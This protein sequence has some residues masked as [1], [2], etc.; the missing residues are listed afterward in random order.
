MVQNR[1]TNILE[2]YLQEKIKT[3]VSIGSIRLDLPESLVLEGLY[4][5]NP[6]QD[7]FLSLGELSINFKLNKLLQ[8]SIQFDEL[9]LSEGTVDLF[10]SADSNNFD[11]IT[12]A[13]LNSNEAQITE[14]SIKNN[15]TSAWDFTFNPSK[16]YV[17]NVDFSY[18]KAG[19]L[20]LVTHIGSLESRIHS[21]DLKNLDFRTEDLHLSDSQIDL[22]MFEKVED[23]DTTSTSP[24]HFAI[25][26][27][28]AEIKEVTFNL[29]M[30]TTS[31]RTN[32]PILE[33][34][35]FAFQWNG[36]DVK[37]NM[38]EAITSGTAIRYDLIGAIK[39][40][41]FDY[42]HLDLSNISFELADFEYHNMNIKADIQQL[43]GTTN[44]GFKIKHTEGLFTFSKNRISLD[45][46]VFLTERSD[47]KSK[48][49]VINYPFLD[50]VTDPLS[51]L[52]IDSDLRFKGSNSA[53]LSYFYPPL[54]SILF[55]KKNKALPVVLNAAIEGS[56][57]E[58]LAINKFDLELI[59]LRVNIVGSTGNILSSNQQSWDI[60]VKEFKTLKEK[61]SYLIPEKTLPDFVQ[62]PDSISITGRTNGS[63]QD[64]QTQLIAETNRINTPIPTLIKAN[65]RFKNISSQ[66]SAFLDL[67]ID[68]FYTSRSDVLA[69]LPPD[70][71]PEYVE[72]PEYFLLNGSING[73]FSNLNSNLNLSTYRNKKEQAFKAL[74]SITGLFT[75]EKPGFDLV[76]DAAD[77]SQEELK[78]FLPDSLLPAYFNL[79]LIKKLTG[80]FKG[81]LE[82]FDTN[83]ELESNSGQW[84]VD[85]SLKDKAYDLKFNIEG[86]KAKELFTEGYLDSLTGYSFA[87]LSVDVELNGKG[88]EMAEDAFSDF[89]IRIKSAANQEMEGLVIEGKLDK[90]LLQAKAFANEKEIA[91]N[92]NFELDYSNSL[93]VWRLDM[94]LDSIDLQAME[95]VEYPF[96]LSANIKAE[97]KGYNLDQLDGKALIADFGILYK[98]STQQIDSILLV[99]DFD[100]TKSIAQITSDF[101]DANLTGKIKYPE[102]T[103]A[104]QQLIYN[105]FDTSFSDSLVGKTAD[106][107]ELDFQLHRPELL[108]MGFIPDLKE[109]PA[110]NFNSTYNNENGTIDFTSNVPYFS[111]QQSTFDNINI[112][113]KGNPEGLNY[114]VDCVNAS[115]Q[116][117]LRLNKVSSYGALIDNV[118]DNTM[119]LLDSTDQKQFELKST[120][121][122]SQNKDL[123]LSFASEQILNYE[124]WS[125]S[126]NN[127]VSWENSQLAIKDWQLFTNKETIIISK[128]EKEQFELSFEN[129][130]LDVFSKL[131]KTPT[132]PSGKMKEQ[133]II[134]LDGILNGQL[135]FS[136]PSQKSTFTSKLQ[137]NDFVLFNAQLGKVK[138]DAFKEDGT[139]VN[140][141]A[142]IQGNGNDLRIGG[143]IDLEENFDALN[144]KLDIPALNLSA[145][146]P[147]LFGYLENMEG[148]L[149][150]KLQINGSLAQPDITGKV[151]FKETEFD[152]ELVKARLKLGTE[153]LVFDAN[154]IE[155]KNLSINDASGNKGIMSSYILTDDYRTFYLQSN[156]NVKNFQVLNTTASDNDLYYGKLFVDAKAN[157]SGTLQAPIIELNA[158]TTKNSDLTYV[159]SAV[160]N[161]VESHAGIVEFIA[162][163]KKNERKINNEK[164]GK[165]SKGLNMK[166]IVKAQVNESLNFKAITDPITGDYFEGKAKGDLVYVQHPDGLMELNGDLTLVNGS[167]LFT[168]QKVIRRPFEVRP[169]GTISWSG[170]P[171]NPRFNL[172]V[173]YKIKTS[174]YPLLASNSGNNT[175][176]LKQIFLVRLNIDGTLNKTKISTALEYPEGEGNDNN[177]D[178]KAAIDQI[179]QDPGQQNTQAFS[180]ILF[181]GFIA[182]EGGPSPFKVIDLSGNINNIITSQ[183]NNIANRYIK[184]VDLDFNLDTDTDAN[185]NLTADFSVS[186]KK[187]FLNDRLVISLDGKTTSDSGNEEGGSQSYLDNVTVEYALTSDGRFKIKIY[188]KREYDDFIEGTGVKVGGAFVFSKEF[189]GFRIKER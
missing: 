94:Q 138:L 70:A 187:R 126:E 16:L 57:K 34:K 46:F 181:N 189:N 1:L 37:V 78:A 167:Y 184:F 53:D 182:N 118:L 113:V 55:F 107:F 165:L 153:D 42:K 63:L 56:F 105:Y 119:Q 88:F 45:D 152:L 66:D 171:L 151:N 125:V 86:L 114:Q 99:A 61:I 141:T 54:D 76:L 109:L 145:I 175:S 89:L 93:P 139:K 85:A 11:F 27:N 166:I 133:N 176:Q 150:G 67:Q 95:Y 132:E 12:E 28:S 81:D 162:P 134:G 72:L 156:L 49:T 65:G 43:A 80:I 2:N 90:Y 40:P 17:Y 47:L 15:N 140:A 154:V 121:R 97:A 83:F 116:K 180:I 103:T 25:E 14:D 22:T 62:L 73:L 52:E 177:T 24:V 186:I 41:G 170:D 21:I 160:S 188:N 4:I 124:K 20:N 74:G 130:D 32:I 31:F 136:D 131:I 148:F 137:I 71:L 7:T 91:V 59:D 149:T 6:H 92:S 96:L 155:F 129:F 101:F 60:E 23:N 84:K 122:F 69:Y 98:D 48:H 117:R 144:F 18:H 183:L 112:K 115:I 19:D 75:D 173:L 100:S 35:E 128:L 5:E 174:A 8:K 87:P 104:I 110:F 3:K 120:S 26:A 168:Y 36:N 146:E 9:L 161:Q 159:Y 178:I 108:L 82:N 79:P 64:F 58:Y 185:S 123:H 51:Q 68:T 102:T 172:A 143:N 163:I 30:P 135:S 50:S 111:W 164:I 29:E 33:S 77:F 106:H 127:L 157:L 169:G 13:F 142:S 38:A 10:M 147:L 158:V 44:K 39:S 179:N